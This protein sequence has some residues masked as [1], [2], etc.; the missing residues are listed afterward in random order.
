MGD[1]LLD[2]VG[3]ADARARVGGVVSGLVPRWEIPE[4]SLGAKTNR[5]PAMGKYRRRTGIGLRFF[6]FADHRILGELVLIHVRVEVAD[7]GTTGFGIADAFRGVFLQQLARASRFA[8][9]LLVRT[10]RHLGLGIF[11]EL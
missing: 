10:L 11:V 2:A 6:L 9:Q 1:A 4:R 3:L 5:S 7:L 8:K